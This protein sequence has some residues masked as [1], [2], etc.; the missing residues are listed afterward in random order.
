MRNVIIG[1]AGH[2]D[3]GKTELIRALTGIDTDR[4]GEEKKRGI[5]I[6]LGFAWLDLPD[7]TRAGIVDVPG[8]ERFIRNM[9]AGAG[10]ID[11]ALLIVAADE[12]VMPQTVEHLGILSLLEIKTGIVVVTKTDLV[13]PEW[14]ELVE[15]QVGELTEGTFLE[16]APRCF[17][18]AVK[19]DGIEDL[20]QIIIEL[21]GAVDKKKTSAPFR[22]PI[23]RVFSL[24]G[25]GT[26][27]TG[28][29]IEGSVTVGSEVE[30][31][32]E[33]RKMRV[34]NIEV[35]GERVETAV[36]G[37]RVA[38][39][40]SG[41]ERDAIER[42]DLLAAPGSV[43]NS[44]LLDVRLVCL[45]EATFRIRTGSRLHL[46]LGSRELLCR[47]Y[48]LD[49]DELGPGEQT[50]AQLRLEEEVSVKTGD[51]FIVRFF[52]PL[53]TIGGGTVLDPLPDRHRRYRLET[54]DSLE[55]LD[56]G[57]AKEQV[58]YVIERAKDVFEQIGEAKMRS[59]LDDDVFENALSELL[60]DGTV[61]KVED[62]Y[63]IGEDRLETLVAE[64]VSILKA[65][66]KEEPLQTGMKREELRTRLLRRA[67]IGLTDKLLDLMIARGA[68]R[69]DGGRMAAA[70]FKLK[71]DENVKKLIDEL[72]VLYLDAAYMPPDTS[73]VIDSLKKRGD[74][75]KVLDNM[76]ASG[77][78]VRLDQQ[79]IMHADTVSDAKKR[80]E[81]ALN[82]PGSIS[83]A[84]FRDSVKTSRKFAVAV[85][86]YFDRNKLT[87]LVDGVRVRY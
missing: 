15:D 54:R 14:L 49:R 58:A 3:H 1:T 51:H 27:V 77:R 52:S 11:L 84:D 69:D 6:E 44:S 78:L 86:E 4:L 63:Y 87:R 42:G 22:L 55:K 73:E 70:G 41:V 59:G 39:N 65:F 17:V 75:R 68:I 57:S 7:G 50:Y 28:T 74:I 72:D 25:F 16:K 79:I 36:A 9:L 66:H 47:V 56:G 62:K 85:L 5:T 2:V 81:A 34:R 18:S 37:Q 13:D 38:V 33:G 20:R 43:V 83:L 24:E 35:H 46:Y 26:I 21:V 64:A 71:I 40:L 32:P 8:H 31:Y 76:I 80:V 61:H 29:L 10:G 45:P 19:G 82:D 30:L 53:Q 12:G 48:L 23:D 60:A 67:P